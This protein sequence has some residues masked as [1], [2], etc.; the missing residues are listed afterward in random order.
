MEIEGL[1]FFVVDL[2]LGRVCYRGGNINNNSRG[3]YF[4]FGWDWAVY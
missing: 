2:C 3:I 1:M 4:Y